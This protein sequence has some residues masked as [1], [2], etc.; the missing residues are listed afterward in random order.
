MYDYKSTGIIRVSDQLQKV[1][2]STHGP[3]LG[4]AHRLDNDGIYFA[5]EKIRKYSKRV[6]ASF[7]DTSAFHQ[8]NI[9][10][11]GAPRIHSPSD[12]VCPFT[13]SS[14]STCTDS[15]YIRRPITTHKRTS[16]KSEIVF[17]LVDN[18]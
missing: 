9:T 3:L 11:P 10:G 16:P 6:S 5:K 4:D 1:N 15:L 12:L 14:H 8:A 13:L 17:D 18:Q 7:E 2:T